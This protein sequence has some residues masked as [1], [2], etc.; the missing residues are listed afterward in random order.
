MSVMSLS[1]SAVDTALTDEAVAD[2]L[3]TMTR[4]DVDDDGVYS[5]QD[6]KILL[7]AAAG[8]ETE[9]EDYDI[10]LDGQV[11]L[12]DAQKMLRVAADLENVVDNETLLMFFS[13]SL[14]GIKTKK[15]GFSRTTTNLCPS[16]KVTTSGAPVSSLNVTNMEYRDYVNNLVK[17]MN[18]FPYNTMLDDD[19]KQELELMKKSAVEVYEPQVENK[20][21]AA[22][23]NSHY[24][25]FP[26]NNLG[27]VCKLS[28]SEIKTIKQ[29]VVD[30][31]FVITV[32]LNNYTYGKGEYP[33]G[34]AGFSERQKLP[35]G[36]VFNLPSLNESDGSVVNSVTLK[37]GIIVLTLDGETGK[38]VEVD[39]SY[40]YVS[41]ITSA[42]TEGS[43]LVM[44][45]VTTA[46]TN[47]NY[48]INKE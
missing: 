34:S 24:T 12:L 17:V 35:Y 47:E 29:T 31:N 13:D 21:V 28:L 5:T 26:V 42:K 3:V 43:E 41:D 8:I 22:T 39:Y 9:E 48:V 40:S 20:V 10:D 38:P 46:N 19:M 44:K 32:T 4:A 23:S 15:P 30:G 33:T 6:A 25:N 2:I 27:W 36:K 7:R 14:N 18:S 45:T 11:S 37:N 16:I 1:V